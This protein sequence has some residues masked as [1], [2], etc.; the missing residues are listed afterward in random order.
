MKN[1]RRK[2][3]F[4]KLEPRCLMAT[5]DS[6]SSTSVAFSTATP[7][8]ASEIGSYLPVTS[9]I[10]NNVSTVANGLVSASFQPP[11]KLASQMLKTL[12]VSDRLS[13]AVGEYLKTNP[14]FTLGNMTHAE[15]VK[16]IPRLLSPVIA[17]P[18]LINVVPGIPTPLK[19]A[20]KNII[21][22]GDITVPVTVPTT[23]PTPT[24]TNVPKVKP[25]PN[26]VMPPPTVAKPFVLPTKPTTPNASASPLINQPVKRNPVVLDNTKVSSATNPI[27]A[28]PKTSKPIVMKPVVSKPI[29]SK[30]TDLPQSTI[31]IPKDK[32]VVPI[33]L[34]SNSDAAKTSGSFASTGVVQIPPNIVVPSVITIHPTQDT[35]VDSKVAVTNE[36]ISSAGPSTVTKEVS[37]DQPIISAS[38][39]SM[40]APF[41]AKTL[42]LYQ[43][44]V[45]QVLAE[46]SV[47]GSISRMNQTTQSLFSPSKSTAMSQSSAFKQYSMPTSMDGLELQSATHEFTNPFTSFI[48]VLRSHFRRI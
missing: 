18:S 20:I 21:A 44:Q 48:R 9:R 29:V 32:P 22:Q 43:S 17:N 47:S 37:V 3:G 33:H 30:P 39:T 36:I 28:N 46:L 40:V 8:D 19:T 24:T 38:A 34:G 2:Y 10:S 42:A 25:A 27:S 35:F 5:L 15:L 13:T 14:S 1:T 45:D 16:S 23:K 11:A 7:S 12:T 41:I 26:P 4:E 6:F 31:S